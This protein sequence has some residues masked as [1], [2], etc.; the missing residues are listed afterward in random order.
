VKKY[1][2][3]TPFQLFVQYWATVGVQNIVGILDLEKL[4]VK[5]FQ[6]KAQGWDPSSSYMHVQKLWKK[7]VNKIQLSSI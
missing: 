7:V 4:V 2:K 6:Y 3:S 1:P 5:H